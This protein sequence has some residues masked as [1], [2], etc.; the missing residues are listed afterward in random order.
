MT[1]LTKKQ[2]KLYNLEQDGIMKY[3][4]RLSTN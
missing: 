1:I 4:I 2:A 3:R